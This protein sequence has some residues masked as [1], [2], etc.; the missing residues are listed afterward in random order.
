MP[1]QSLVTEYVRRRPL[2]GTGTG[3]IS[4]QCVCLSAGKLPP[5]S[6]SS[7]DP[8]LAWTA[9][10]MYP[11]P[12]QP[13]VQNLQP[14]PLLVKQ[15]RWCIEERPKR[16]DSFH[17][18]RLEKQMSS[19]MGV[20]F[21]HFVLESWVWTWDHLSIGVWLKVGVI[22]CFNSKT[23]DRHWEVAIHFLV[24]KGKGSSTSSNYVCIIYMALHTVQM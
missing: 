5:P 6:D 12:V 7:G 18:K 4:E 13:R 11:P 23:C 10:E 1:R 22:F 9:G 24:T 17:Q 16:N 15:R 21:K 8:L 2:P 3:A 20:D 14:T 19:L